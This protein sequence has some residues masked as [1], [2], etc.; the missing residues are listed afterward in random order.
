[1]P[2]NGGENQSFEYLPSITEANTQ[3]WMNHSQWLQSTQHRFIGLTPFTTYNVTVYVRQ[4]NNKHIDS[5]YLYIN[6]TTAEGKPNQYVSLDQCLY[7]FFFSLLGVPTEPLNVTVTQL[8]NSRVRISWEPPKDAYG[9]LKEYTVYYR[10]QTISVQ[11]A[12]SVKVSPH[13]HSIVLESNLEPNTTYEYWVRVRNSKNESPSSKLVRLTFD[14]SLDMDRLT[15]LHVTHIGPNYIQ[16]EWNKIKNVDGYFIQIILPTKY[17]KLSSY[18]TNQTNFRIENLIQ[19][20]NI[21][22]KVS[23]FKEKFFGRPSSISSILPG[24]PLP[25]V[26]KIN[27]SETN[28]QVLVSWAVPNA[29]AIKNLTYGIYYG[30]TVEELYEKPRITTTSLQKILKDLLPCESYLISVGISGPVGPGPLSSPIIQETKYNENKP[31]RNVKANMNSET[32][33]LEITWEANCPLLRQYPSSYIISMTE[34]TKN[35]TSAV[36]LKRSGEKLLSHRFEDIPDGAVFILKISTNA[37]RAEPVTLKVHAPPLPAVRQLK[38]YP[39][40]NGSYVVFWNDVNDKT[41][42]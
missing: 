4:K 28:G 33:V 18:Q 13:E 10:A 16:V 1:M 15:G 19:G 3:N 27:V 22:I 41:K 32:H 8:N 2:I 31:P 35:R 40:K 11:Q 21:N 38:V 20:V 36:E 14:Q 30:T 34:L 39:E 29:I 25:E 6:V 42:R 26:P 23:G 17:P 12:H 37:K 5:P 24:T 7:S 9:I